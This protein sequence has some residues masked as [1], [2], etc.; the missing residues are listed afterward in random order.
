MLYIILCVYIKKKQKKKRLKTTTQNKSINLLL[1]TIRGN[2]FDN[3]AKK[4]SKNF[5]FDD[6]NFIYTPTNRPSRW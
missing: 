5:I 1:R 2:V 6:G 4:P 3:N